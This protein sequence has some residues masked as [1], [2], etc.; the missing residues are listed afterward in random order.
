LLSPLG[1]LADLQT[2]NNDVHLLGVRRVLE[3]ESA[4][5]AAAL[6]T[7]PELERLNSILDE[8]DAVLAGDPP[9]DL[10]AFIHSDTEFHRGIA[11]ASGNPALSALIETLIGRTLRTRLWRAIGENDAVSHTQ[12]EHRAILRELR[13][14]EPDRARLRMSMHVLDVEEYAFSHPSDSVGET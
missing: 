2:R 10:E 4:A 9:V 12:L 5:R 14:H 11:R 3:A 13:R 7:G 8:A 6:I 1:F